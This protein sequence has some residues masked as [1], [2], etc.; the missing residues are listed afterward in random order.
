MA[1][2]HII[3][4]VL[5][6]KHFEEPNL[7]CKWSIQTG[8][9]WK[10]LEGAPEGET[11]TDRSR[12]EHNKSVFCAPI[13]LHLALRSIQGWPKLHVEIYSVTPFDRFYPVGFGFAH[14]P[15]RP[16]AHQLEL[17]TWKVA[18]NTVLDSVQQKFH[19]GGLTVAKSDLIYS[20]VE[21]YKL[22]TLSSGVVRVE[23]M[24]IFKDFDKFG[25]ELQ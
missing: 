5:D 3:G 8:P 2:L 9:F 12:F 24:L 22:K 1:E 15:I 23:L 17:P 6:A 7:F 20:G 10:V 11:S 4:Q 19:A 13:D 21:R 14:L 18:P 16:G 25:V